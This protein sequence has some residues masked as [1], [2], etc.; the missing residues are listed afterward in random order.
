MS[1][2][3]K[4]KFGGQQAELMRAL[5]ITPE[6]L[7][8]NDA[9]I[10][11]ENQRET[12]VR[13]QMYRWWPFL[14]PAGIFLFMPLIYLVIAVAEPETVLPMLL[15]ALGFLGG[16]AGFGGAVWWQWQQLQRDLAKGEVR[17]VQGI[18]VVNVNQARNT[19]NSYLEIG[20]LKLKASPKVL[21]RVRHLDP[22]IVNYLPESKV[23]LSMQHIDEDQNIRQG[24]AESRLADVVS[25]ENIDGS[26][27]AD[28]STDQQQS[29]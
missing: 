21:L 26:T 18:A 14:I 29:H 25:D 8:A 22:Y 27:Y 24:E 13:R 5:D 10:I 3:K 28:E 20:D 7:E 15:T 4:K 6:D 19:Y 23:I 1:E 2:P 17:T 16:A 12:I 11:T 9:G